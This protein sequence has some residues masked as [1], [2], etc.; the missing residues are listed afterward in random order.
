MCLLSHHSD[1]CHKNR[2]KWFKLSI[3]QYISNIQGEV[4]VLLCLH[5]FSRCGVYGQIHFLDMSET[6]SY[7]LY[8]KVNVD[9]FHD[10]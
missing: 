8:S 1:I 5:V 9:R 6:K 4:W 2:L 7:F 3:F 10:L